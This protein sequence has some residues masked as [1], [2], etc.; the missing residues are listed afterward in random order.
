M[1]WLYYINKNSV[2]GKQKQNFKTMSSNICAIT[3]E[4]LGHQ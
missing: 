2:T 1:V 3:T 4:A